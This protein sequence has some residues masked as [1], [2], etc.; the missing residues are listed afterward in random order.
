[1][2]SILRAKGADAQLTTF[3]GADH[4]AVPALAYLD[5]EIGL[6]SWLTSHTLPQTQ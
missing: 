3:A 1:M 5:E 6:L 4:F 2:V